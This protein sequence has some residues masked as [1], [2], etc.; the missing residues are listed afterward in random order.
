MYKLPVVEN[1]EQKEVVVFCDNGKKHSAGKNKVNEEN[2]E[3]GQAENYDETAKNDDGDDDIDEIA[4]DDHEQ[5]DKSNE[6]EDKE[7]DHIKAEKISRTEASKRMLKK[8]DVDC[9]Q[10][11]V[12]LCHITTCFTPLTF[13]AVICMIK[14][15]ATKETEKDDVLIGKLARITAANIT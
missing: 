3:Q 14:V 6:D 4:M 8:R 15:F 11:F 5:D 12:D 7:N 2:K 9:Q 13:N 10:K 1:I